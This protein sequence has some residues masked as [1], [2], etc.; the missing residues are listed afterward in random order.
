CFNDNGCRNPFSA[1]GG[2]NFWFANPEVSP[3]FGMFAVVVVDAVDT[4]QVTMTR[5]PAPG[6]ALVPGTFEAENFDQ[7]GEGVAYHD[8]TPGNQGDAGFRIGE[9]VDI[10]VSNDAGSGS[11]YI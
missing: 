9:D 3:L 7:G 4:A 5:R 10:F 6:L 11:P 2:G 8:S 1:I